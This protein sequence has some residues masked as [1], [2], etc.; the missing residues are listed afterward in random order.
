[1]TGGFDR[2]VAG[3]VAVTLVV[4]A[5][6]A[7]A[8]ASRVV[9]ASSDPELT[10]ALT[11]ALVPAAVIPVGERGDLNAPDATARARALTASEGGA[12]AVWVV[13]RSPTSSSVMVFDR[14]LDRIVA[15]DL[16]YAPPYTAAQAASIAL[17]VRTLLR[18]HHLQPEPASPPAPEI[19]ARDRGGRGWALSVE[20]GAG[21]RFGGWAA[22]GFPAAT[23]GVVGR[24]PLFDVA[25]TVAS[26]AAERR[27]GSTYAGRLEDH[28]LAATLRLPVRHG[29]FA[30]EP[31]IGASLHWARAT[32]TLP[33]D[34]GRTVDV[35]RLDPA[36]RASAAAAWLVTRR[37]EPALWCESDLM[38]RRQRLLS[39]AT[40][41]AALSRVQAA[42]V[43][44]VR[45]GAS[46]P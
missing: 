46:R 5:S 26:G 45:L 15:R 8:A 35:E 10:Q 9:L 38:L 6:P 41:V 4:L 43:L 37:A 40:R 3:T 13:S 20:A 17:M 44:G 31:G 16:A 11:T 28:A 22:V 33:E 23:V 39:G 7:W 12:V 42:C 14:S 1:M 24:G 32:G 34:G 2:L 18:A 29:T 25:L 27:E 19:A 21:A 30:L 36:L